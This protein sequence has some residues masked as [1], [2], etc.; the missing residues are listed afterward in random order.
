MPASL[1]KKCPFC[2]EEIQ[3]AAVVCRF[4]GREFRS[5]RPQRSMGQVIALVVMTLIG[6]V[7]ALIVIGVL[8]SVSS[9]TRSDTASTSDPRAEVLLKAISGVGESCDEVIEVYHQGSRPDVGDFWNARCRNGRSYSVRQQ[10]SGEV[11]VLSCQMM[12]AVANVN[13]FKPFSR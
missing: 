1:M 9:S 8:L 10:T 5:S 12:K 13:C 7:G 3:D 4:C 11:Q 2:G 6:C